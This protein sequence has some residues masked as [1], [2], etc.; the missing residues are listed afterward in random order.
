[1]TDSTAAY[2]GGNRWGKLIGQ[3]FLV[4]Y[5][6]ETYHENFRPG[7]QGLGSSRGR[8][9]SRGGGKGNTGSRAFLHQRDPLFSTNAAGWVRNL[10]SNLAHTKNTRVLTQFS[11][12]R[13]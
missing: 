1:M 4:Y 7:K 13:V 2:I 9:N 3:S 5:T 11:A 8:T 6:R 12:G 10:F